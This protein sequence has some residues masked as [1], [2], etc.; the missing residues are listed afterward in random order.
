[1]PKEVRLRVAVLMGGVSAEREVSLKSGRQVAVALTERG[2]D[3]HAVD[4]TAPNVDMLDALKP[5]AVFVALHGAFGEDGRVQA[6]LERKGLPY[7]GSGP[8][9]S[10]KGMDKLASKR[11]FIM[12]GVPTPDYLVVDGP[13]DVARAARGVERLGY[14]VV[15]KPVAGGSSIGVS[16]CRSARELSDG[17]QRAFQADPSG[18][19]LVERYQQG[20]ELTVGVLD[21]EPLPLVEIR[22]GR[23]FFDYE[24][25]YVDKGTSYLLDVALPPA[26][27]LRAQEVGVG[28]CRALGCRHMAR[29]DVIYGEDGR[30]Y[31]L[32][33][34]TIPGCT[35]RSLLP[36]AAAA[37]GIEFAE[38]CHRL[39]RMAL[40]DAA[41]AG[42]RSAAA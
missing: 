10:R 29:T 18:A 23:A 17:I 22:T 35:S 14:P 20:R 5:H 37:Q 40:R 34:N 31:V 13:L 6:E 16:L 7:V 39:V 30:F 3:V 42:V 21:G 1:M 41:Q 2:Y 4:V 36:M 33:V 15:C 9:A 11:A 12:H 38:L 27:Y 25:K 24:A 26:V 32:E 28:A 8:E 19:V